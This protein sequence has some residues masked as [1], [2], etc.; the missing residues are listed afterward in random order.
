MP[1]GSC[2]LLCQVWFDW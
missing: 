1:C 2:F